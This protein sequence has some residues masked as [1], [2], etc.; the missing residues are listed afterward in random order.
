MRLIK[1]LNASS[2]REAKRK[3][4]NK[5]DQS[6]TAGSRVFEHGKFRRSKIKVPSA[7]CDVVR[8][9]NEYE[10]GKRERRVWHKMYGVSSLPWNTP[11]NGVWVPSIAGVSAVRKLRDLT[12]NVRHTSRGLLGNLLF[13]PHTKKAVS[14]N[15]CPDDNSDDQSLLYLT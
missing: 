12:L 4:R 3:K 8:D 2:W 5:S 9:V 6:V 15:V 14:A 10:E 13:D 1:G 11:F 7:F